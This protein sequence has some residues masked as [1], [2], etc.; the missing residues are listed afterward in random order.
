MCSLMH[1]KPPAPPSSVGQKP[2]ALCWGFHLPGGSPTPPVC[3]QHYLG[4]L[5]SVLCRLC[6]SHV[7]SSY[8]CL[9]PQLH[10]C[11]CLSLS[12]T[13][14]PRS[15]T[16]VVN[17]LSPVPAFPVPAWTQFLSPQSQ[18]MAVSSLILVHNNSKPSVSLLMQNVFFYTMQPTKV[19]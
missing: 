19:I 1:V 12:S 16:K 10:M 8:M 11:A 4:S 6:M 18:G 3:I 17:A 2:K 15:E 7:P 9:V 14:W 13:Y 5:E